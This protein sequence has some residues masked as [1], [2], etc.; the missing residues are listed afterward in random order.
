MTRGISDLRKHRRIW[1]DLHDRLLVALRRN[2]P[3]E[4]L[5]HVRSRLARRA[6]KF[7]AKARG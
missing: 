6:L 3:R 7:S 2:E 1:E 5:E 4:V